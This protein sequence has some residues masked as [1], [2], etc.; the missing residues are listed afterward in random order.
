MTHDKLS[1]GSRIV[2]VFH[3]LTGSQQPSCTVH[4]S[5]WL[6][7]AR[8]ICLDVTRGVDRPPSSTTMHC[9]ADVTDARGAPPFF[10]L[11]RTDEQPVTSVIKA[12]AIKQIGP[13]SKWMSAGMCI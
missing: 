9:H 10:W 2:V 6:S 3:R 7:C 12:G 13:T 11:W 4:S 1:N 8:L 5:K